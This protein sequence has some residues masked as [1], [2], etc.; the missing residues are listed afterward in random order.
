MLRGVILTLALATAGI[1]A[2]DDLNT[3]DNDYASVVEQSGLKAGDG[4]FRVKVGGHTE[5]IGGVIESS[6]AA[7]D[8]GKNSLTTATLATRDLANHADYEGQSVSVGIS[9]STEKKDDGSPVGYGGFNAAPPAAMNAE[10]SQRSITR[11]GI[12]GGELVITD[13]AGQA[14]RTGQ[15]PE[16]AVAALNR[17]VTTGQDSTHAIHNT[18]NPDAIQAAFDVTAAFTREIGTYLDYRAKEADQLQ[19]QIDAELGKPAD[20]VDHARLNQLTGELAG[21]QT[22]QMGGTGRQVLTA[23]VG[24]A[25]GNVTGA[26][27]DMVRAMAVN[28]LQSLTAA[29][30]KN[31]ADGLKDANGQATPESELVRATLQGLAACAGAGAQGGDCGNA[32]LAAG[33]NTVIN[34]LLGETEGLTAEQREARQNLIGNLVAGVSATGGSAATATTAARI[35]GENNALFLFPLAVKLADL[36]FTAYDAWQLQKAVREGRTADAEEIAAGMAL[37]VVPGGKA[38]DKIRDVLGKSGKVGQ[39]VAKSTTAERIVGA[40]GGAE[41]TTVIGRVKDLQKLGPGEKSLLDRLPNLGNPKAN[42]QQ[43]AGVLREEMRLGRPIRDASPLDK[44]GQFLNA[45]RNLLKERGWMFDEATNF[46]MP[47]KP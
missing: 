46:W 26:A 39:D 11:G 44:T 33:A 28:Y 12:S 35:E 32:A 16:A 7:V 18:F 19:N 38:V 27:G 2:G 30:I 29:E 14:A 3:L 22:W 5:L 17:D 13:A 1:A 24:A 34:T 42:W 25:S 40:K 37:A 36:G 6:Q 20:Q 21:L 15:T 4:G 10:G 9:Y 23:L 41:T 47:P 8:Q 31:Y 45:E 43:N